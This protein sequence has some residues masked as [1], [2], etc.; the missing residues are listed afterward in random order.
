MARD[1]ILINE[2]RVDCIVGV[3][4]HERLRPQP[5]LIDL[6]LG[7]VMFPAMIYGVF[8]GIKKI[9]SENGKW[10]WNFLT[11]PA[12]LLFLFAVIYSLV[13]VLTWTLIRYRLPVDA[14]LIPFAALALSDISQRF[15]KK[16]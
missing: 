8:L 1:R 7:L 2:L 13:H 11:S 9:S 5:L 15:S 12:G 3:F 4:E 16:T 6:E 10:L 14:V